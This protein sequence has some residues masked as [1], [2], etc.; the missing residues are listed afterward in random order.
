MTPKFSPLQVRTE[1]IK[2]VMGDS[3]G[4][5][6]PNL[7]HRTVRRLLFLLEKIEQS[8]DNGSRIACEVATGDE[9]GGFEPS[10]AGA[11]SGK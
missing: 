6:R 5:V 1:S 4:I 7:V 11:P 8:G 10:W 3:S 2:L 9:E